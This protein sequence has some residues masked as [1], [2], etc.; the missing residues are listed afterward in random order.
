L[1]SVLLVCGLG[2]VGCDKK[3][4]TPAAPG[5]TST[6]AP[7]G[8]KMAGPDKMAS[9]DPVKDKV[10]AA[11]KAD[12]KLKD[13]AITVEHKDGKVVLKGEVADTAAKKQANEV[14]TKAIKDAASTDKLQNMLTAKS[15]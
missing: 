11:L 8:D 7:G 13:A 5:P 1:A 3:E 2:I 14:A 10:D 6:T 12:D 4:E 9:A 15:H